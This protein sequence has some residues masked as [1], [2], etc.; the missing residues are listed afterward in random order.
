MRRRKFWN[1]IILQHLENTSIPFPLK[2]QVKGDDICLVCSASFYKIQNIINHVL[3][4]N[5]Y[6]DQMTQQNEHKMPA[7]IVYL[8]II[9]YNH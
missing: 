3:S 9:A 2:W 4:V 8:I 1:L 7:L 6:S 5:C